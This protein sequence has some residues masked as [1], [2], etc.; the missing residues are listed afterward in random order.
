MSL[1]ATSG[2]IFSKEF[3]ESVTNGSKTQTTRVW[4]ESQFS[5]LKR[6]ALNGKV[7]PARSNWSNDTIF[8]Y[9]ICWKVQECK[10][11]SLTSSDISREGVSVEHDT[12]REFLEKHFPDCATDKSRFEHN[13]SACV[14]FYVRFKYVGVSAADLPED[15]A[16]LQWEDAERRCCVCGLEANNH[17]CVVCDRYVSLIFFLLCLV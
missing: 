12:V 8:G 13:G 2:I 15:I 9:L 11:N 16:D 7:I 10:L 6:A 1:A 4:S 5:A 17:T 14:S 3:V